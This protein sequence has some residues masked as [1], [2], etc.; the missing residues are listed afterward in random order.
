L[1]ALRQVL[2]PWRPLALT[3]EIA[4][5]A[6]GELEAVFHRHPRQ[7]RELLE[8]LTRLLSNGRL[9]EW[10]LA[11]GVE[12]GEVLT[13][14]LEALPKTGAAGLEALPAYGVRWLFSATAPFPTDGGEVQQ[15]KALADWIDRN[16]DRRL[17]GLRLLES[18]WLELWLESSGRMPS[19]GGLEPIRAAS[20]SEQ[21]RIEMLLRLLDPSRPPARPEVSPAALDFGRHPAGAVV[22]RT[23]KIDNRGAGHL[24]GTCILEGQTAG[25]RLDPVTFDGTPASLRLR[26]DTG[27]IPPFTS[28]KATLAINCYDGGSRHVLEVPVR[29]SV[30]VRLADKIGRSLLAGLTAGVTYGLLRMLTG[31]SLAETES[32][33]L[34]RI[35]VGRIEQTFYDSFF[36]LLWLLLLGLGL[37][38]ALVGTFVYLTRVCRR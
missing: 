17:A 25:L 31:I 8:A 35:S 10:I 19:P 36:E 4:L 32:V 30:R 5:E 11:S 26:I 24:W 33:P 20:C 12:G 6:P 28:S 27:G 22:E 18:G 9:S 29:Y 7:R 2:D 23:L 3:R 38:G 13:Q 15:P 14:R 37:L 21:A 34:D 1:F 16:R